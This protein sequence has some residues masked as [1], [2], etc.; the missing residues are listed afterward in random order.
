MGAMNVSTR[1]NRDVRRPSVLRVLYAEAHRRVATLDFCGVV[2]G[3]LR[4]RRCSVM[5]AGLDDRLI[6]E[7]AIGLPTGLT[8][9]AGGA[10]GTGIA[11]RVARE[12][13]PLL[14]RGPEDLDSWPPSNRAYP[15]DSFISYPMTLPGGGVAVVNV[16]E[17]EDGRPFDERD[18]ETLEQLVAFYVSTYDAPSRRETLRLRGEIQ[19]LRRHAIRVQEHERSRIARDLHDGSGH[20]LSAAILRLDMMAAGTGDAASVEAIAV[21][22]QALLE[23]SD[24]LHENAFHLR[25][26]VLLDLGIAPA[27]RSLARRLHEGIETK[28]RIYGEERRF[29]EQIELALFRIAQE[30]TTN[31]IRHARAKHLAISLATTEGSVV[32]EVTDDGVGLSSAGLDCSDEHDGQGLQSMRERA[33]LAGGVLEILTQP[34]AGTTVRA[35]IPVGGT[36]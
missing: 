19:N 10:V 7:E 11:G 22:K 21:A 17:R 18:L 25:P 3:I 1:T 6:V 36:P 29:G 14:V 4:C 32:L 26:R 35:V 27:L 23:C 15:T 8:G 30:A 34:G 28:V 31:A 13:R 9:M 33:A 20:V 16:T 5:M 24:H 12:G 2:A